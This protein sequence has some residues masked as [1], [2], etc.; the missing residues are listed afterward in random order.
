VSTFTVFSF[1]ATFLFGQ[2]PGVQVEAKTLAQM[3]P[4]VAEKSL[5]ELLKDDALWFNYKNQT[6]LLEYLQIAENLRRPGL[7][8]V[9]ATNI[10][11]PRVLEWRLMDT[12]REYPAYGAL[13]KIGIPAVHGII[14]ELKGFDPENPPPGLTREEIEEIKDESVREK[15]LKEYYKA[16]SDQE[17]LGH[18]ANKEHRQL[19][20][21]SCLVEIYGQGG[22]G[23]DLARLRLEKEALK[24]SGKERER[25][26]KA[27]K[28]PQLK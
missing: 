9:L 27:L 3:P 15:K 4:S 8:Q 11:C 13:R 6:R 23:K 17:K 26:L 5:F 2:N 14:M 21:L 18:R 16:I 24:S 1:V 12:G 28:H 25:L 22:Y 19:L 20:L 7:A 10:T